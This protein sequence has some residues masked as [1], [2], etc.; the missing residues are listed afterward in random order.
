MSEFLENQRKRKEQQENQ[1]NAGLSQGAMDAIRDF[2]AGGGQLPPGMDQMM[3]GGALSQGAMDAISDFQAQ[4]GQLPPGMAEMLGGMMPQQGAPMGQQ[5]MDMKPAEYYDPEADNGGKSP[6]F[7]GET[8]MLEGDTTHQMEGVD[9]AMGLQAGG[10]RPVE[11]GKAPGPEGRDSGS[12]DAWGSARASGAQAVQ[13]TGD[14]PTMP[15]TG[16]GPRMTK[17]RLQRANMTLKKYKAGKAQLERR[18]VENER[19][20]E[21]RQWMSQQ[22]VGNLQSAHRPTMWLFNVIMG[23]HADMVEAYPEP[24]ILPREEGDQEEAQR[25]TSI[26]PVVLEQND[27]EETYSL[28]AWE[29]NKHGTGAY[30]I[31]WDQS[32]ENGLGDISIVGVDLVNLFWEPGIDDLEKSQNL[33]HVTSQDIH[34]LKQQY[35]QLEGQALETDFTIQKYDTEDL[36]NANDGKALVIDW[37]YHT[38]EDGRKV[39]QYCKYCGLTVLYASEDDPALQ[40]KGWYDDGEYPFVFDRLFPKKGTPAGKGYI[41]IGRNAQE[42]IDLLSEA[43]SINSRAGAIPRWL[44][45]ED[46]T[47]NEKEFLDFTKPFVHVAGGVN[48]HNTMPMNTVPLNGNYVS[49]LQNKIE[50]LKQTCGNQDVTNGITNGVTA[51]SGI[52]AQMEAAGRSSRDA[53]KGTY[54]AYS[55]IIGK[56]IERIRQFYDMP[57]QFRITGENGQ[58]EFESYDN[59]G[60][61]MQP[62]ESIGGMDM[63]LRKPVFDIHVGAQKQNTYSKMA[64]NELALQLLNAGVFTPELADQSLLLLD[65]MDFNQKDDIVRKIQEM[66]DTKEQLAMW[67]QMAMEL[68]SKYEPEMAEQMAQAI[69]GQEM[70]AAPME[71][72]ASGE[73]VELPEEGIPEDSRMQKARQRSREASQV[74]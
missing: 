13:D 16:R 43:I 42:E 22:E 64:N 14:D 41:D 7:Q 6:Y 2:Q 60:L 73:E 30:A 65:M 54:R 55:R 35:P 70:G 38:Y 4:G 19:W 59:S 63:G 68:A 15:A 44:V 11:T 5:P 37:Y 29:K 8:G 24:V 50:E 32:K 40:G 52:A 53:V 48:E 3:Q 23:K 45:G 72:A 46:A 49:V 17:E 20:W 1:L 33:F 58:M 12:Q 71:M 28:Q 31:Y 39:L 36:K 56:V 51:A 69:M 10:I 66:S 74:E 67:Q 34:L 25:L 26:L 61:M 9:F 18:L 57:R 21:A 47:I 62:Q 27:F